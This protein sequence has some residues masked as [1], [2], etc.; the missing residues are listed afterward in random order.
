MG[1]HR[2]FQPGHGG[3]PLPDG[4]PP[5]QRRQHLLQPP[6]LRRVVLGRYHQ[7][8][9][10][11]VIKLRVDAAALQRRR[12]LRAGVAVPF[13]TQR[14]LQRLAGADLPSPCRQP[15]TQTLQLRQQRLQLL[16]IVRQQLVGSVQRL[17]N[18]I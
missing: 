16:R 11:R 4:L 17:Q 18:K 13:G 10:I 14:H 8:H 3:R 15:T 9:M 1:R 7:H 6:Q 12:Y 2:L 5:G